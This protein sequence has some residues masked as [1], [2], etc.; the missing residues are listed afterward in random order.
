MSIKEKNEHTINVAPRLFTGK[1]FI[2]YFLFPHYA[3]CDVISEENKQFKL[4]YLI[5]KTLPR[6]SKKRTFITVLN[7]LS[8]LVKLLNQ[9]ICT[10]MYKLEHP[11]Y[12]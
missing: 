1:H 8:P 9:T 3:K 4:K 7:I 11:L 2:I 5:N 12:N 10:G 6:K